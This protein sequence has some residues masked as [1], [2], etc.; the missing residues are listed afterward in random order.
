MCAPSIPDPNQAALAGQETDLGNLP[1]TWAINQAA[2]SGSRV[3][4]NGH[5]YDFTGMGNA[6]VQGRVDD[7][8][9][10][11]LLDIQ[12][13]YG[14][15]YVAQ[16]LA[17]LQ[18]ADPEGYAARQ[19][20]FDRILQQ[21]HDN[22]DRPLNDELQNQVNSML[23]DSGHLD[24]K[25]L[26]EV[27]QGVRGKQVG[28]GIVLGN[29]PASEESSAVVNAS[30]NLAEQQQA[31]AGQYLSSGVSPQDVAYRNIVQSLSNLGAFVNSQTPTAQFNQVSGAQGGAAPFTSTSYQPN[32]ALNPAAGANGMNAA[33]SIYNSQSQ[34]SNP[35]LT[36]LA[37]GLNTYN[38]FNNWTNQGT[39]SNQA[40]NNLF[41]SA[42]NPGFAMTTNTG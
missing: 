8:M 34:Q 31:E 37:T 18:R 23:Q 14:S 32:G 22:P 40:Y 15:A 33:N 41:N 28:R 21:S 7:Q 42:N 12:N 17:D 13:N 5:T 11:A 27:Q 1:F 3:T 25:G 9:A 6:A 19:D 29:A 20:L 24:K 26:E 39:S 35:W 36:G 16:R 30:D 2:Q 38:A 4:I 10:Q